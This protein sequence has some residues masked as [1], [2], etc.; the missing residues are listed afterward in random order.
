MNLNP[1]RPWIT[2]L[3]MGAFLLTAMTGVLMFFHLDAGLNKLAHEWLSWAMVGG[4]LLHV[5]LNLAAF[6][7][8]FS[9]KTA[10]LVM[11]VFAL[12]LVLSFMPVAAK[13]KAPS[14]AGPVR[15]LAQAP[16]PVLAQVLG[17]S[18]EDL[19]RDLEKAGLPV[20]SDSQSLQDLVGTDLK[21]QVRALNRLLPGAEH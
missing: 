3:V 15:A 9:Q 2:P 5:L 6:K 8:Y 20:D 13:K 11:G 16:L 10:L 17:K 1:H 21:Q 4:V 18:P 19:Q 7:R 12:V 14:H